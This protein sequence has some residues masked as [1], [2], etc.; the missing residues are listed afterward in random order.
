MRHSLCHSVSDRYSLWRIDDMWYIF[1]H[2]TDICVY[3]DP[4]ESTC[5]CVLMDLNHA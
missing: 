3:M 5:R 1:K 4:N 2:N